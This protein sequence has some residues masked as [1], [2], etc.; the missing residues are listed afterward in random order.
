MCRS[1][2]SSAQSAIH[3][4]RQRPRL[5][6]ND[7]RE[8]Q[9][10]RPLHCSQIFA[11]WEDHERS[12]ISQAGIPASRKS[13]HCST[14]VTINLR[15]GFEMTRSHKYCSAFPRKRFSAFIL[16][17]IFAVTDFCLAALP[18]NGVPQDA[19]I[20]S[21][22]KSDHG[23]AW[24]Q[25]NR[26][27]LVLNDPP[28]QTEIKL[29]R[30]ANVAKQIYLQ[31][32]SGKFLQINPERKTWII[33][34]DPASSAALEILVIEL[35]APPRVFDESVAAAPDD[36]QIVFLPAKFGTT[37]GE[38]L[39]FEPQPHKNT[40][41]YWSNVK[42]TAD[43]RFSLQKSGDYEIDILQGCG[44]GHGGSQ[45]EVHVES[46]SL[47]FEVQETGHFQNFVWR[48]I[49]TV[50]LKESDKEVLK[51]IPLKKAAGAVMDVRAVRLVPVG[52]KRSF[53]SELADPAS[54]PN[55]P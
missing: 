23:T 40:I 36:Q 22:W 52:T 47:M 55:S 29:P 20:W 33:K 5:L 35:D 25:M 31:S 54:L 21:H 13:T 53:D 11:N 48:T 49:G 45:V 39:R 30:L 34:L 51:L 19:K 43:W 9:K 46:Q 24:E 12:F 38:N 15:R 37:H 32:D 8:L 28:K 26:L 7:G 50:S 6:N 3:E 2:I 16:I 42:D 14:N 44:K 4:F 27:F 41:G 1:E 18:P 17:L 10:K